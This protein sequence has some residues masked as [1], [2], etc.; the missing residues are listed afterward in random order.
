MQV[1]TLR[2]T[3][4]I[5]DSDALMRQKSCAKLAQHGIAHLGE[6]L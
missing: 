4:A 5:D 2:S 1:Q 3:V 6:E